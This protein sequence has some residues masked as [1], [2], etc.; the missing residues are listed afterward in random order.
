MFRIMR[1][2]FRVSLATALLSSAAFL[3]PA[4]R[5]VFDYSLSSGDEGVAEARMLSVA[6]SDFE[7]E[8]ETALAEDD[9][10]LARSIQ[11]LA[12]DRGVAIDP[13]LVRRIGEA[14]AFS[15]TK[16]AGQAWAGL[17]SGDT[18]T[19]TAFAGSLVA[20]LSVA[21][22]LR[23]LYSELSKY[24]DYDE[25]TVGLASLGIAATGATIV[26]GM[27]GLPAKAG[28]S[29]LKSA[30]KAGKL[31]PSLQRELRDIAARSIDGD[32]A[33]AAFRAAKSLDTTALSASARRIVRPEAIERLGSTARSIGG[34]A[35]QQG[36]RGTLQT[37]KLAETTDDIRKLEKAS[38]RYGDRY[39]AVARFV[40]KAGGIALKAGAFIALMAWW[41]LGIAVWVA[42]LGLFAVDLV[43][44]AL[45]LTMPR[46]RIVAA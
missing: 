24:P 12:T 28:V 26:S 22:D 9:D 27:N 31:P 39:R 2:A 20:D 13:D 8:I 34:V 4:A 36:Y 7:S 40:G 14:G 18:E 16:S 33:A 10:E 19:P 11:L 42:G 38:T 5:I 30:K 44:T 29:L 21:G 3:Y 37:L 25:L 35:G 6:P 41:M 15:F 1:F 46:R 43:M 32:E 17:V 45:R 23:D